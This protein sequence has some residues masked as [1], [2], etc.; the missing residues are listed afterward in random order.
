MKR[1]VQFTALTMALVTLITPVLALLLGYFLNA[2]TVGS[3][4]LLGSAMILL[5]LVLYQG[6]LM[7]N[8]CIK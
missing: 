8:R 1:S 7:R 4:A 6:E 2:E 3:L 5:G